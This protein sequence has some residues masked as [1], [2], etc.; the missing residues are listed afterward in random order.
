VESSSSTVWLHFLPRRL[1]ISTV[2][3]SFYIHYLILPFSGVCDHRLVWSPPL[4]FEVAA[5]LLVR[6]PCAL[7]SVLAICS[8]PQVCL[9]SLVQGPHCLVSLPPVLR[10]GS[11]FSLDFFHVL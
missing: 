2:S 10:S 3:F 7:V 11:S 1:L 6:F 9:S 8:V 4:W 5:L